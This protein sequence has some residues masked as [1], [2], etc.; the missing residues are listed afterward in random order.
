MAAK[1]TKGTPS[2]ADA[3]QGDVNQTAAAAPAAALPQDDPA[4]KGEQTGD[5]SAAPATPAPGAPDAD[6]ATAEDGV[7]QPAAAAPAV[8]APADDLDGPLNESRAPIAISGSSPG[9]AA[10]K[11]DA[12]DE[13]ELLGYL[14]TD[15]SS[16]LHDGT[17]Y[18]LGD[19]IFLNDKEAA[20]LLARRIIEP[21]GSKK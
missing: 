3:A 5:Q 13:P 12:T 8:P 20:P 14:V 2:A 19:D 17:W 9:D 16:V 6:A 7:N 4:A 21:S 18:H 10:L 15:V 1:P 11:D